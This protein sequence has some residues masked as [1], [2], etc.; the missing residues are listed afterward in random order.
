MRRN[1]CLNQMEASRCPDI[2]DYLL[3]SVSL[4]LPLGQVPPTFE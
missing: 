2:I 3:V 1:G 4:S